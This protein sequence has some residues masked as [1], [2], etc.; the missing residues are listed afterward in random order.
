VATLQRTAFRGGGGDRA[1]LPPAQAPG[2]DFSQIRVAATAG[3][4]ALKVAATGDARDREAERVAETM[5]RQDSVR[6]RVGEGSAPLN[7]AGTS[8]VDSGVSERLRARKGAGAPLGG[9]AR[10]FF[11]PRFG[12]DF[13]SV[14]VHADGEAARLSAALGTRAFTYAG[15]MYFGAGQLNAGTADG[16]RL[17]AHELAHVVQQ[18]RGA[19]LVEKAPPPDPTDTKLDELKAEL[20]ATYGLSDVVDGDTKWTLPH[21]QE[22]RDAFK[23]LPAGDKAALSGVVLR[24]VTTL[25]GSTAGK[26]RSNQG[27]TGTT[28]VNEA[29]IEISDR[30]YL[31]P[32]PGSHLVIVH[33]VGH[34]VA[35]LPGRIATHASHV[36]FA[37]A[38]QLIATSNKDV[39][40]LNA[41]VEAS[42]NLV[43]P[44]ND[45]VK[46]LNAA[47][48]TTD[49]DRKAAAKD[50]YDRLKKEFD[51]KK[52]EEGRLR[53]ISDA[54]GAKSKAATLEAEQKQLASKS[55]EISAAALSSIKADA[56]AKEAAQIVAAA[57][58]KT[59][60]GGFAPDKQT[61]SEAYRTAVTEAGSAIKTFAGNTAGQTLSEDDVETEIAKT[62]AMVD[63]RN[64]A[65][66]AL[67][68]ADKRNPA[69]AAFAPVE[70]AQD[71]WFASA[72]AHALA[73]QRS[74]RV[75]KF[76]DFVEKNNIAPVTPY[77]ETN[78][79]HKPE[80]FYAEAYAMFLVTPADLKAKSLALHDWFAAKKYL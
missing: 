67:A 20:K 39:E 17:L 27:V 10:A 15:G 56:D 4:P 7:E 77:A 75:Q 36:A 61:A 26:F 51:A 29:T 46:E 66:E 71:A 34:A 53:A 21:L 41:A 65:R 19:Q 13:G 76:V 30:A 18:R 1:T 52:A 59:A 58:A 28:V 55:L 60:A 24:R 12:H 33:E 37:K 16:R 35:S 45:A 62:R 64:A 32:A 42:N 3:Q 22:V 9:A 78:W 23:L 11:E 48:A 68:T 73:H 54:S 49:K 72:R 50:A 2:H 74:A 25:G 63:A 44:L 80:E 38:N 14:R 47:N 6:R 31:N 70:L 43:D 5:V 8:E 69:P 79:P 57:A 40:A